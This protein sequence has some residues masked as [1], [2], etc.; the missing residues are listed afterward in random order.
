MT[1]GISLQYPKTLVFTSWNIF[2]FSFQLLKMEKDIEYQILNFLQQQHNNTTETSRIK[3][4]VRVDNQSL[5]RHLYKL[6]R[7]GILIK[8]NES[9]PTWQLNLNRKQNTQRKAQS[10]PKHYSGRNYNPIYGRKVK[11]NVIYNSENFECNY[12]SRHALFYFHFHIST[13]YV[14]EIIK[15]FIG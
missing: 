7:D 13:K 14:G 12:K 3:Q 4:V 5:N 11:I 1:I 8:I 15:S 9:P 2:G 10:K 6:K